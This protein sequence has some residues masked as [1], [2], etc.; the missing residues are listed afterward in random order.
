VNP[1]DAHEDLT[2]RA[3]SWL[4]A[5][6]SA[7]HVPAGGGNA[8]MDLE[9][10]K[11]LHGLNIVDVKPIHTSFGLPDARLI[12]P[13]DPDRSVLLKRIATRGPNQMPQ[14]STNRVDEQG[15]ALMR[16]WIQSLKKSP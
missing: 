6:C 10:S 7:C 2:K 12:A 9:F 13:G 14:L 16:E 3:K 11:S 4:H 1:Y 15:V 8:Q 5:N